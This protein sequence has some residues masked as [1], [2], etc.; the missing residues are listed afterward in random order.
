MSD[1]QPHQQKYCFPLNVSLFNLEW[2][3]VPFWFASS[4]QVKEKDNP[5]KEIGFT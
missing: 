3:P 2:Y 5:R 4:Q 1:E